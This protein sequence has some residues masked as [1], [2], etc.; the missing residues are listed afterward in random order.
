MNV[1]NFAR[2]GKGPLTR[3]VGLQ[4]NFKEYYEETK[5]LDEA[6]SG[7]FSCPNYKDKQFLEFLPDVMQ[8]SVLDTCKSCEHAVMCNSYKIHYVNEKNHFGYKPRLKGNAIKLLII[9]HFL[10]PNK[11]G[12]IS[13]VLINELATFLRCDIKTVKN[14]NLM[15]SGYGYISYSNSGLK[16]AINIM[17]PEYTTYHLNAAEGGRGY[18]TM[19]SDLLNKII[20]IKDLNQLRIYLRTLMDSDASCA[21]DVSLQKSFT[22]LRRYLPD[23]CKPNVIQKALKLE[24]SIFEVTYDKQVVTLHLNKLYNTRIAKE[25][26][27]N[28]Y[29]DSLHRF[30]DDFNHTLDQFNAPIKNFEDITTPYHINTGASYYPPLIIRLQDYADLANLATAYSLSVVEDVI[31]V[32]YNTYILQNK[33]IES[34]GAL[35]RT[36]IKNEVSLTKAS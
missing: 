19:S 6:A 2:I 35:A 26:L 14:C 30:V 10:S 25:K 24:S 12:I 33:C 32:I 23:Y 9:Y 11:K 3:A 34:F 22:E 18:T 1:A 29:N 16:G 13:D 4:K 27:T 15:L 20:D 8:Q 36:I 17:L 7:C 31:P 5:Q 21:Q 28:E